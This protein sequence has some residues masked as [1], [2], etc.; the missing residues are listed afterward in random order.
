M[1]L[2][3]LFIDKAFLKIKDYLENGSKFR[4]NLEVHEIEIMTF[5]ASLLLVKATSTNKKNDQLIRKF[6]LME[7]MR[8]EMYLEADLLNPGSSLGT[9]QQAKLILSKT[10]LELFNTELEWEANLCKMKMLDYVKRSA[11]ISE[12][13]YKLINMPL[14]KGYVWLQPTEI[15]RVFRE[16][17]SSYMFQKVK[18]MP[19]KQLPSLILDKSNILIEIYN[20]HKPIPLMGHNNN[21]SGGGITPPCIQHLV[22]EMEN[23]VNLSH[24]ARIL[25]ATFLFKSGRTMDDVVSLFRTLPDFN[26]SITRYQL[27]HLAGQKGSRQIYSVPSCSKILGNNLCFRSDVICKNVV[28][29][30]QLLNKS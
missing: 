6:A 21:S 14:Q 4:Y 23:G 3:S 10:Y 11:K 12:Q 30:A 27:S 5:L 8:F 13:R 2:D 24:F 22:K 26:E 18:E 17:M 25:V 1:D 20:K 29:P 19:V 9:Q 28:N 16:D 7:A 15:T